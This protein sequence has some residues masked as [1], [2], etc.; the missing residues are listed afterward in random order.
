MKTVGACR[1]LRYIGVLKNQF[2]MT[3][4]AVAYNLVRMANLQ[5][6]PA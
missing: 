1:K 5:A 3:M 2:W 4:E 6:R